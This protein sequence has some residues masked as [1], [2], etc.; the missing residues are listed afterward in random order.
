[1][2]ILLLTNNFTAKPFFARLVADIF[3]AA[4]DSP[5]VA[6]IA[7]IHPCEDPRFYSDLSPSPNYSVESGRLRDIARPGDVAIGVCTSAVLD[8][9]ELHLPAYVIDREVG[10]DTGFVE[11]GLATALF[12][13][14]GTLCTEFVDLL[15]GT[16]VAAPPAERDKQVEYYLGPKGDAFDRELQSLVAAALGD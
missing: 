9:V 15:Q 13:N 14:N 12:D 2:R 5:T 8:C 16:A 7:K 10:C 1:M 6:V 11:S 3:S 4:G